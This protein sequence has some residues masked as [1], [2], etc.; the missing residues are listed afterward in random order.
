MSQTQSD[1]D[2]GRDRRFSTARQADLREEVRRRARPPRACLPKRSRF[3]QPE[4]ERCA[5]EAGEVAA[6]TAGR[7]GREMRRRLQQVICLRMEC[8]REIVQL[9]LHAVTLNALV[10]RAR[11]IHWYRSSS[12]AASGNQ[13][14]D[15]GRAGCGAPSTDRARPE[16]AARCVGPGRSAVAASVA[17]AH[18]V[19]HAR[20]PGPC[21][22]R[23]PLMPRRMRPSPP[24][25]G[26]SPPRGRSLPP[27]SRG[28]SGR[29]YRHRRR[30]VGAGGP[31]RRGQ[32]RRPRR[33]GG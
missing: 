1:F 12:G 15:V 26:R 8:G 5:S 3:T 19:V 21:A 32:R 22:F 9:R 13:R 4:D 2:H 10:P 20:R 14:T 25:S 11:S 6:D 31:G 27:W 17:L 16:P 30:G 24:R 7:Q 28:P 18:C 33:R 29:R 23:A